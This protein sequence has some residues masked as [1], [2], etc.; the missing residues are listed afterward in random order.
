MTSIRTRPAA[1]L[2]VLVLSAFAAI[3]AGGCSSKGPKLYPVKGR[4]TFADGRPVQG[5]TIEF[6][7]TAER[8]SSIGQ[9]QQDGTFRLTTNEEGDAALPGPHIVIITQGYVPLSSKPAHFHGPRVPAKYSS[10]ET[11]GLTVEVE[12]GDN[13]VPIVLDAE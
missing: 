11:S 3:A 9:I 13:D 7:S 8:S 12:A 5:G 4:V 10:Y 1:H 2:A 6:T